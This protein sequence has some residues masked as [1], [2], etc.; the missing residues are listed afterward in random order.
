MAYRSVYCVLTL[1]PA[2]AV[3]TERTSHNQLWTTLVRNDVAQVA[4]H[5]IV[6]FC[7]EQHAIKVNNLNAAHW[8]NIICKRGGVSNGV[9]AISATSRMQ[10]PT[11]TFIYRNL[12]TQ[13]TGQR[14]YSQCLNPVDFS[15]LGALQ[16]K[17]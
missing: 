4:V 7:G 1:I 16:Q 15:V 5:Q 3:L 9:I 14:V 2:I 11:C 6:Q 8:L 10:L 13:K 12:S 17:V